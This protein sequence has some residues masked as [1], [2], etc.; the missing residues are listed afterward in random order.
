M[1]YRTRNILVAAGLAVLAVVFMLIYVSKARN[2]GDVG[3]Q[4]ESVL[5]AARNIDAGTPGA[6]LSGG[7]LVEKRI[8]R[9]AVIPDPAT[10]PNQLNGLVAT[11]DTLSGEQVSLRRFG[12]IAATGVLAKVTK[13]QRVVQLA[14]DANQVLDGTL[15]AGNRVDIMGSWT[16]VGCQN[17]RVSAVIVRNAL[18]LATSADLGSVGGAGS[19]TKPVQLRL[20]DAQANVVFWMEKNGAWWLTLR[21]VIKPRNTKLSES[22]AQSILKYLKQQGLTK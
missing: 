19:S 15:R 6:T 20:T 1:T 17:C 21:P 9:K 13:R 22:T 7:A 11:E 5:V 12:P 16:P 10:S 18:V 8:P 14:G 4:L 3:K 2:D